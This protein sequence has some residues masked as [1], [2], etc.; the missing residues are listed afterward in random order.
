[1]GV[2]ARKVKERTSQ[3][4]ALKNQISELENELVELRSKSWH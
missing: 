3:L 4:I 2:L 1:V